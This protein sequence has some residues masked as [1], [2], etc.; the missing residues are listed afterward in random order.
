MEQPFHAVAALDERQDRLLM[1]TVYAP[2]R[3]EWE[4][5]WRTRR[6]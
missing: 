5:D 2:S 3:E 6:W 1:V 4:S